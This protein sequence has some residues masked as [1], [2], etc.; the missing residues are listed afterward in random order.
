MS[1]LFLFVQFEFTHAIGPHAGRYVVEP[2]LLSDAEP[3]SDDQ[4]SLDPSLDTRNRQLAGTTRGVGA[5]DVFVVGVIGAPAAQRRVL[6]RAREIDAGDAPSEVPLSLATFV[7]GSRPLQHEREA[8]AKLQEIRFSE[9]LQREW[10]RD[11]L[12]VLNL[13][14]RAYRAGAPD[15]YAV[16]VTRRDARRIRVGY[17]T[18][19]DVQNG[20]FRE[21]FELPPRQQPRATRIE[22][23]RPSEAVAT[24]LTGRA[25]VLEGEDLLLRSLVDL[26]QNRTR[27]AACQVAAALRLVW[28][29][30]R[31]KPDVNR[32]DFGA[33]QRASE[34]GD[35]LARV[36]TERSLTDAE[37]TELESLIDAVA[38]IIDGWRYHQLESS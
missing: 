20:R 31:A 3:A 37:V 9:Q 16:E 26:D 6:R 25:E 11:G 36:A 7:K 28:Y 13:A 14:I 33:V 2:R 24:V 27:A 38:G 8:D 32:V 30:L 29:E 1:L 21:A 10:V 18:T 12:H 5:S 15:P 22:R 35:G 34:T 23:L 17:G 19:E 4:P